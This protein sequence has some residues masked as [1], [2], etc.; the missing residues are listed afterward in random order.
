MCRKQTKQGAKAQQCSRVYW[1]FEFITVKDFLYITQQYWTPSVNGVLW[2]QIPILRKTSMCFWN[3]KEIFSTQ[4]LGKWEDLTCCIKCFKGKSHNWHVKCLL[5]CTTRKQRNSVPRHEHL[6]LE[7]TIERHTMDMKKALRTAACFA[8]FHR[9]PEQPGL[10]NRD[11][12][13]YLEF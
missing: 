5:S 2:W 6:K 1:V 3:K 11:T 12:H 13:F 9:K 10:L 4:R 8:K 7:R